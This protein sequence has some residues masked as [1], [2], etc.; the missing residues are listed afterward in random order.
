M[1]DDSI[2]MVILE[3]DMEYAV[4]LRVTHCVPQTT[5]VP[6][7]HPKGPGPYRQ[8]SFQPALEAVCP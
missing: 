6:T 5:S 3:I 1:G 7:T 8:R 2:D 4:T